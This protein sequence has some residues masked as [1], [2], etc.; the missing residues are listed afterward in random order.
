[1]EGAPACLPTCEIRRGRT[2]VAQCTQNRPRAGHLRRR[3]QPE[4]PPHLAPGVEL[5]TLVVLR[6]LEERLE[7]LVGGIFLRALLENLDGLL[8]FAPLALA[9][10]VDGVEQRLALVAPH[11]RVE[12]LLHL[13]VLLLA[14]HLRAEHG[15][16]L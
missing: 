1:M 2:S 7:L 3:L 12:D 4:L 10:G 5:E 11:G 15:L 13:G 8:L 9:P 14:E 16:R 6:A